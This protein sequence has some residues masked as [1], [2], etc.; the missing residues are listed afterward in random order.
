MGSA[1]H[2]GSLT[3]DY[4]S[5]FAIASVNGAPLSVTGNAVVA[6]PVLLGGL[7]NTTSTTTSGQFIVRQITFANAQGTTPNAANVAI[8]TSN[9]G[10]SSNIVT[11]NTVLSNL[12]G[13]TKYQD[14]SYTGT[15]NTTI[16]A[17]NTQA[18]FLCVN[19][20]GGAGSTVDVTIYGDLVTL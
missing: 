12:T 11:A 14:V 10:N 8:Y 3:P 5:R 6:L 9:D 16:S 19:G 15:A 18:F 1:N 20:A 7:T 4:F 17:A 13:S 2:V